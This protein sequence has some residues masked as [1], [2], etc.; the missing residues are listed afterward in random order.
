MQNSVLRAGYAARIV[1][2]KSSVVDDSVE[3]KSESKPKASRKRKGGVQVVEPVC[4]VRSNVFFASL[5]AL[6]VERGADVTVESLAGGAVSVVVFRPLEDPRSSPSLS[7]RLDASVGQS[8]PG[9]ARG[10]GLNDKFPNFITAHLTV[11]EQGEGLLDYL[12]INETRP[13]E[14]LGIS[15]ILTADMVAEPEFVTRCLEDIANDLCQ[16]DREF[17]IH[18]YVRSISEQAYHD[19]GIAREN[20]L[21]GTLTI[22][23]GGLMLRRYRA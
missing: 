15:R 1:E 21:V 7:K 2:L 6:C 8:H 16:S 4:P 3:V 5:E 17:D 22:A 18:R 11:E 19:Y 9:G 10:D 12:V 13:E 14:G 23:H 20:P